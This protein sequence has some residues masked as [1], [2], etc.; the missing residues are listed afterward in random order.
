[1]KMFWNNG[2]RSMIMIE[3]EEGWPLIAAEE[4]GAAAAQE[5]A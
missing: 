2:K 4:Y 5:E 1:M 3:D